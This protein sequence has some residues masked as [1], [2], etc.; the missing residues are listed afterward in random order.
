MGRPPELSERGG[1]VE[2]SPFAHHPLSFEHEDDGQAK[3]DITPR[4][5]Q[6]APVSSVGS[7][8]S[9]LQDHSFGCVMERFWVELEIGEASLLFLEPGGVARGPV[10][11]LSGGHALVA[12][13]RETPDAA[14]EA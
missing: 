4:R 14:S 3:V 10:P 7:R 5:G 2:V 11:E 13:G 1:D 8:E 9:A 12:G 6:A